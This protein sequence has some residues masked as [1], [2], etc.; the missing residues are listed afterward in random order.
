MTDDDVAVR[1]RTDQSPD[2]AV[3]I[4]WILSGKV[5]ADPNADGFTPV[6]GWDGETPLW[7]GGPA[8]LHPPALSGVAEWLWAELHTRSDET[9]V[10]YAQQ[11]GRQTL[12]V[13]V[14]DQQWMV[15]EVYG[16]PQAGH[17]P[18]LIEIGDGLFAG[19]SIQGVYRGDWFVAQDH[20]PFL[21]DMESRT[22]HPLLGLPDGEEGYAE[23]WRAIPLDVE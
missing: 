5:F 7:G 1:E 17:V 13:A 20:V 15:R 6:A 2:S 19:Y 22:V 10:W 18:Y 4:R 14:V 23:P 8:D 9:T 12:L 11:D 16:W 21:I 3:Q